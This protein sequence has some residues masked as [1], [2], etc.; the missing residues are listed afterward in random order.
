M[1]TFIDAAAGTPPVANHVPHLHIRWDQDKVR[2]TPK[3]AMQQLRG[4]TPSIEANPATGKD[5]LVLGAWM[6]QPGEAEVVARRVQQVLNLK[7]A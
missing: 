1:P 3:E 7:A 2:L 4:G 6:L 5:E